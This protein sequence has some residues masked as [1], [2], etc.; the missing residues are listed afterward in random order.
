MRAA[1]TLWLGIVFNLVLGTSNALAQVNPLAGLGVILMHGKG[2]QPGG[3]DR[4]LSAALELEGALTSKPQM[5]WAGSRG[6]PSDYN[7]S[8]VLALSVIDREISKLKAGGATRIVVAGQ[9]LGANGALAYAASNPGKVDAVVMLAAGHVPEQFHKNPEIA[10][11]TAAA[12]KLVEEGKGSESGSY[13]D[14]NQGR[15]AWVPA[16][17]S[18]YLSYFDLEGP[19]VMRLNAMRFSA[20]IPVLYVIGRQDP[21]Y[22]QGRGFV[23]DRL[24]LNPSHG[25]IEI[26]AGHLDTPDKAVN[27]VVKWLK[28]L[29]P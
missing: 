24:P 20:S 11:A 9:S 29:K 5:A 6:V 19:A 22:A 21:L 27:E 18:A 15:F 25:Y 2:G 26:D 16:I 14:I 28:D 17:A 1:K 13:P 10:R 4:A 8:F 7:T 23:I 12:K 3:R